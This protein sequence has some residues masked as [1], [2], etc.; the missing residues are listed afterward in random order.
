MEQTA[1]SKDLYTLVIKSS[2]YFEKGEYPVI[3]QGEHIYPVFEMIKIS[4][5][6]VNFLLLFL[7]INSDF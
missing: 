4:F 5:I 6:R 3:D 7:E 2:D 1:Q